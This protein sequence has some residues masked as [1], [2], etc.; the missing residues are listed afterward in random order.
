[1][2]KCVY[3]FIHTYEM[4]A[5]K[6]LSHDLHINNAQCYKYVYVHIHEGKYDFNTYICNTY[7]YEFICACTHVC[8]HIY[9]MPSKYMYIHTYICTRIM[10]VGVY[11]RVCVCV[12]ACARACVLKSDISLASPAHKRYAYILHMQTMSAYVWIDA[13][14]CVCIRRYICVCMYTCIQTYTFTQYHAQLQIK[15]GTK[16][17]K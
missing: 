17:R 12:C 11:A 7:M 10:F 2:R 1:M 15:E 5:L 14:L 4:C 8:I 3:V 16:N 6:F 13:Y 9:V